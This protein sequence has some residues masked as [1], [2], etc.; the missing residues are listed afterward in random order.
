LFKF[1]SLTLSDPKDPT[2][3]PDLIVWPEAAVT[4][5]LADDNEFMTEVADIIPYSSYLVLGSVRQEGWMINRKIFN[6]VQFIDSEGN[7]ETSHYDKFHL[8]PFGEYVPLRSILPFVDKLAKGIGDFNK[9][10]GPKTIKLPNA[11][12]FSPLICYEIIFPGN[13]KK[14][15]RCSKT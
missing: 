15:S 2:Y 13:V 12:A 14:Q 7:L 1:Y 8:V 10:E 6:S 3:V 4:T 5:N 9:G 11:P